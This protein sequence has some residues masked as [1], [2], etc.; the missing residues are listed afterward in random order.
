MEEEPV[1]EGHE[2]GCHQLDK[3]HVARRGE[4]KGKE[5]GHGARRYHGAEQPQCFAPIRA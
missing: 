3:C 4:A 1:Q 2:V 5:V